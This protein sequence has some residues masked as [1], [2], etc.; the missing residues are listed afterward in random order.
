[1]LLGRG[2]TITT[3]SF[4]NTNSSA[5]DFE[6]YMHVCHNCCCITVVFYLLNLSSGDSA[7]L[8]SRR[9][10]ILGT[11]SAGP[12]LPCSTNYMANNVDTNYITK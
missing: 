6:E 3:L 7:A 4:S 8:Q 1:M 2:V 10:T 9:G 5:D 11:D 12:C